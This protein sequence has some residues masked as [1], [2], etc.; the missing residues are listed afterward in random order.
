[1]LENLTEKEAVEVALYGCGTGLIGLLLTPFSAYWQAFVVVQIYNWFLKPI[2]GF[3][4]IG[5]ANMVGLPLIIGMLW[6]GF[7]Y[8]KAEK[9]LKKASELLSNYIVYVWLGPLF[10]WG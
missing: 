10:A 1:H 5:V 2:Q 7:T 3:P 9:K 6:V 8:N 4:E